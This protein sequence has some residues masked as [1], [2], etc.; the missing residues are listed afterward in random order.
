MFIPRSV[1][2]LL[3][4]ATVMMRAFGTLEAVAYVGR[5]W[6]RN[7]GTQRSLGSMTRVLRGVTVLLLLH[8]V[9]ASIW[10]VF[11]VAVGAMPDLDTALYFSLTS[12][13]TLGYGDVVLPPSW[14]LLGPFEGAV[15][16]LMFGWSTGI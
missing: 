9:E 12:Y 8:L 1:A 7:K 15:G 4:C 6:H 16:I 5:V 14:R 2:F 3:M 13:T 11:Y 10:A